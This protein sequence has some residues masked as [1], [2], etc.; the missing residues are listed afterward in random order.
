MAARLH[1]KLSALHLAGGRAPEAVAEA[2]AALDAV[3]PSSLVKTVITVASDPYGQP[4]LDEPGIQDAPTDVVDA[5]LSARVLALLYAGDTAGAEVGAEAILGGGRGPGEDALVAAVTALAART[6]TAG[7]VRD[8]LGLARAAVARARGH[9]FSV[10]PR[11]MLG[12]MLQSVGEFGEAGA[13]LEQAADDVEL[14]GDVLWSALPAASRAVL[15]AHQGDLSLAALLAQAALDIS[16]R[17]GTVA[18][19]PQ[20]LAVLARVDVHRGDLREAQQH[21]DDY[22]RASSPSSGGRDARD[23][24][25]D[26]SVG[27]RGRRD[28]AGGLSAAARSVRGLAGD[29]QP[30]AARRA[31][32]RRG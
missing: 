2:E 13:V 19:V 6:W 8:A 9:G 32:Q 18:C 16:G 26:R 24:P 25:L 14:G 11:V 30:A 17:S 23:L 10:H 27:D 1:L 22:K 21:L 31:G 12:A 5:A 4:T 3:Q 20:A 15:H 29:A 28:T 7:R